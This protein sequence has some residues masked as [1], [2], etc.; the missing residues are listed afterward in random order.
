MKTPIRVTDEDICLLGIWV[1][2][3]RCGVVGSV[4]TVGGEVVTDAVRRAGAAWRA[5]ADALAD[6]ETI[7]AGAW[8]LLVN[9]AAM[10]QAL[11][12]KRAP[13]PTESKTVWMGKEPWSVQYGGD[14]DHW[15]V[16]RRLGAH[17]RWTVLQS[18]KLEKAREAWQQG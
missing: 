14:A 13:T 7:G 3:G 4:R 1:A 11:R 17:G 9:D 2:E 15:E 12:S 18:N 8:V 10:F 5:I 16:L 6:A